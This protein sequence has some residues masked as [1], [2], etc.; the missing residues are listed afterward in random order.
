MN[1]EPVFELLEPSLAPEM[2]AISLIFSAIKSSLKLLFERP[3]ALMML[4]SFEVDNWISL[5]PVEHSPNSPN[6]FNWVWLNAS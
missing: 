4:C 5:T 6:P 1:T 2:L 3:I